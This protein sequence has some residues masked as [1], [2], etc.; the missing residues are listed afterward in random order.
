M[1][2]ANGIDVIGEVSETD[3]SPEEFDSTEE[4]LSTQLGT[5]VYDASENSEDISQGDVMMVVETDEGEQA[6]VADRPSNM[7][8][9]D[10]VVEHGTVVSGEGSASGNQYD[11]EVL[12]NVAAMYGLDIAAMDGNVQNRHGET[13]NVSLEPEEEQD[14]FVNRALEN[15]EPIQ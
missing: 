5:E 9:A 11:S 4:Y 14:G 1:S 7:G 13:T 10:E 2:T 3:Y 12:D 6:Y 8:K 15:H